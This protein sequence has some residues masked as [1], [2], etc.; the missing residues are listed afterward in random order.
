[1]S[2]D[3]ELEESRSADTIPPESP[4]HG[5]LEQFESLSHTALEDLASVCRAGLLP[6]ER[7]MMVQVGFKILVL[8]LHDIKEES[9]T[10][11]IQAELDSFM[12]SL[13]P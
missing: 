6:H 12:A 3:E 4:N 1:M 7:L 5:F 11:E 8:A 13:I 10:P 2:E 9:L